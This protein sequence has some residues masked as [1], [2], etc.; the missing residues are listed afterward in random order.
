ML[1]NVPEGIDAANHGYFGG[2]GLIYCCGCKQL[3]R[4]RAGCRLTG[5]DGRGSGDS[6]EYV[7][8]LTI[9]ISPALFHLH[10]LISHKR[11]TLEMCGY[12]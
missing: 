2:E 1:L 7:N 9:T 12:N 3:I 5:R 4:K 6:W 8:Y 11:L 10:P